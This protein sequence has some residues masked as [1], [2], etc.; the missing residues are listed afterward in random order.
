[1]MLV[2]ANGIVL[3]VIREYYTLGCIHMCLSSYGDL[4]HLGETK[5]MCCL[6]CRI[7]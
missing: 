4:V 3:L 6:R 2:G 5:C 7:L 1:M